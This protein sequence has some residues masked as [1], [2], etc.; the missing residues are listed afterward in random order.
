MGNGLKGR[1][2]INQAEKLQ[3]GIKDMKEEENIIRVI[4]TAIQNQSNAFA[5]EYFKQ[6]IEEARE[7][8]YKKGVKDWDKMCSIK[9]GKERDGR[10]GGGK[11]KIK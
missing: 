7:E 9:V 5:V 1:L 10:N 8:G 2:I 4:D 11:I 3:R 6:T